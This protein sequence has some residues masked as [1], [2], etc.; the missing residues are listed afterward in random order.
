MVVRV[1]ILGLILAGGASAQYQPPG[2]LNA[3]EELMIQLIDDYRAENS[4]PAIPVSTVLTA[5]AQ[6]HVADH[7][8]AHDITG[9]WG[10]DPSCNLHSW[11]GVSGAP[12]STCCYTSDHAQALCMWTKPSEISEGTYT[13]TGYEIAAQGF[14]DPAG[15]LNAW[16][17]SSGHNDVILNQGTWASQ[18]WAAMG[19][20]VDTASKRYFVWFA[21]GTDAAGPPEPCGLSGVRGDLVTAL[22]APKAYP[23]PFNPV[24]TITFVMPAAGP[25]A[26]DVFDMSGR[27]VR[28][29]AR[30]T[31]SP[32]PQAVTWNGNDDGGRRAA[33]GA[34]F[35]RLETGGEISTQKILLAK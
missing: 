1:L 18:I 21:T 27:L 31:F 11:Y 26:L 35:V 34:Y 24:T 4:L 9:D 33:S 29:L 25:A 10:S 3:D 8:Y 30:T 2:C 17:G 16:K 20:G 23:N 19:V 12:Y 15:A 22:A 13:S 6:W 14:A 32:G 28:T 7:N 5:V